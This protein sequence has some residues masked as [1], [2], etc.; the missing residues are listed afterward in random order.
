MSSA[1]CDTPSAMM[2]EYRGQ[3]ICPQRLCEI[4]DL[5]W[6]EQMRKQPKTTGKQVGMAV[7]PLNFIFK[8]LQ[9][10]DLADGGAVDCLL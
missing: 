5:H 7:F 2:T 1:E 9:F 8:H 10:L 4:G 3:Q 6:A